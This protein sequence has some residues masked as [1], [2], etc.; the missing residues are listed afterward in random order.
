MPAK[1]A[2]E[3]SYVF[4][5]QNFASR[6][7]WGFLTLYGGDRRQNA[8]QD[9]TDNFRCGGVSMLYR[10]DIVAELIPFLRKDPFLAPV[11][12]MIPELLIK[13]KKLLVFERTP[14]LFQHLG[15][16]STYTGKDQKDRKSETWRSA[17]FMRDETNLTHQGYPVDQNTRY[18]GCFADNKEDRDLDGL[19]ASFSDKKHSGSVLK[20]SIFC[21]DYFYYGLQ[22]GG[23]CLCGNQFGMFG[24]ADE[25]KCDKS[26]SDGLRCG[27]AY[28]NSIYKTVMV[29]AKY[30]GCYKD[31]LKNRDF[32]PHGQVALKGKESVKACSLFCRGSGSQY[33]ALQYG[34]EC[35][36]ASAF[37]KHG[38]AE[39]D[40]LCDM[41]CRGDK[42]TNCGGKLVNS[43]YE[44]IQ[45]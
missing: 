44:I 9:V 17:S 33:L 41:P 34:G 27:G 6:T 36:C 19:F 32:D 28:Y 30:L 31:D 45:I 26:C 16:S 4:A 10:R 20:C 42:T 13:Q 40:G 29:Q 24:Q 37:G 43:V 25:S 35:Y 39:Q 3:K 21:H 38:K 23:E 22:N 11:D 14:N 2:V 18:I 1:Q 12:L 8:V 7:D 15:V 5:H